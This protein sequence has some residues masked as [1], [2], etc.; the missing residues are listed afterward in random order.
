MKIV[1]LDETINRKLKNPK[2]KVAYEKER[3]TLLLK[4]NEQGIKLDIGCGANKQPGFVG[5]DYRK[6]PGV[7]IVQDVEKFPWP[8]PDQCAN[9]AVASHLVEHID[10]HG[11]VFLRFMDEVWR[12]LKYGGQF[13]IATPYAGSHGY[14]QDPTHCNPCNEA[15]WAY[16]DPLEAGGILY[17]IYKPKPWKIDI[18]TWHVN[19]NMEI[20]LSKRK[21]DP[22]YY[23]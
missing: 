15:T 6:L 7:D 2:F 4:Q 16:F 3:I 10:P 19:G 20:V 22:S 21:E 12:I 8:L 9:L 23:E 14:F 13:M 11:G 5:L 17:G 18:N 1:S